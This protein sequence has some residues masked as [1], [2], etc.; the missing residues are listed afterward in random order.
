MDSVQVRHPSISMMYIIVSL[1][2]ISNSVATN[3]IGLE[4]NTL[5]DTDY[6][7]TIA[8]IPTVRTEVECQV[9][10]V[11]HHECQYFTLFTSVSTQVATTSCFLLRSC[12]KKTPCSSNTGCSMAVSGPK[13]PGIVDS[14]CTGLTKKACRGE[15]LSQ[16]YTS[17]GPRDCQ[18]L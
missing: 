12:S 18:N 4:Y 1:M 2:Y 7:S 9:E 16:H 10:C 8:V 5:C 3:C 15:L 17:S 6:V 11:S 14:C 13:T